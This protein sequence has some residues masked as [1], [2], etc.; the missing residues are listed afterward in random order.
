MEIWGKKLFKTYNSTTSSLSKAPSNSSNFSS[1]LRSLSIK[2]AKL[3]GDFQ[4]IL[5]SLGQFLFTKIN[6]SK[7]FD[8]KWH[9]LKLIRIL[10][11]ENILTISI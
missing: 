10:A 5:G 6:L 7:N 9:L 11:S 8:Y 4:P 2:F 1:K 3:K